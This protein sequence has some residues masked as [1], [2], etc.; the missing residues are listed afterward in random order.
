ML[1]YILKLIIYL[2]AC[3]W[4][5]YSVVCLPFHSKYTQHQLLLAYNFSLSCVLFFVLYYTL[6]FVCFFLYFG[7]I[8]ITAMHS[9]S[10]FS[11]FHLQNSTFSLLFFG[12]NAIFS[13]VVCVLIKLNKNAIAFCS[14][15]FGCGSYSYS[16]T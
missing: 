15:L 3:K 1:R 4:N 12:S 16:Y 11:A 9:F 7:S 8:R 6:R 2:I 10:N 5:E 13:F 14:V